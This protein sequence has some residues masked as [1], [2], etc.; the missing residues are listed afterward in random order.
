MSRRRLDP[1][2]LAPFGRMSGPPGESNSRRS[3]LR[4][5]EWRRRNGALARTG[6]S[7]PIIAQRAS[8][9]SRQRSASGNCIQYSHDPLRAHGPTGPRAHGPTG[10]RAYG[11]DRADRRLEVLEEDLVGRRQLDAAALSHESFVPLSDEDV[12][13]VRRHASYE[14]YRIP[15]RLCARD[16]EDRAEWPRRGGPSELRRR[17][18]GRSVRLGERRH[19][20]AG[21][22]RRL[23]DAAD[24]LVLDL[25][26]SRGRRGAAAHPV[27]TGLFGQF[28]QAVLQFSKL[29]S[30]H[31]VLIALDGH[32]QC[33]RCGST[34]SGERRHQIARGAVFQR[35]PALA[36]KPLVE[37]DVF[38]HD[39]TPLLEAMR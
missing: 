34:M 27:E 26:Q 11:H 15:R 29:T 30:A 22:W 6:R 18:C 3:P 17:R 20:L 31:H 8:V 36:V 16:A 21:A 1:I 35:I 12:G 2:L 10:R 14:V 19:D 24:L 32:E 13:R 39:V 33:W 25:P 37:Q 28:G 38:H 5:S 9:G 23:P 4:G 7:V